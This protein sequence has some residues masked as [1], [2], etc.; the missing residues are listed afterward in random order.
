MARGFT[1]T[2]ARGVKPH[3]VERALR[4]GDDEWLCG[5]CYDAE[6]QRRSL[7]AWMRAIAS[8]IEMAGEWCWCE[9]GPMVPSCRCWPY[10]ANQIT[11]AELMFYVSGAFRSIARTRP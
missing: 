1:C 2:G 4:V 5:S 7:P 6:A 9:P 8:R 10:D 11:G 3:E